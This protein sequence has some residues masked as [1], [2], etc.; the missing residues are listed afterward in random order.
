MKRLR[1][2]LC[3]LMLVLSGCSSSIDEKNERK[4]RNGLAEMTINGVKNP[5]M[6]EDFIYIYSAKD[7]LAEPDDSPKNLCFF[8]IYTLNDAA[9]IK[10]D[11]LLYLQKINSLESQP[12]ATKGQKTASVWMPLSEIQPEFFNPFSTNRSRYNR[13]EECV[14]FLAAN[15]PASTTNFVNN[16]PLQ[17]IEEYRV[18][19]KEALEMKAQFSQVVVNPE[20][21]LSIKLMCRANYVYFYDAKK[22][23][24]LVLDFSVLERS[25]NPN[26]Q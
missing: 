19:D 21:L 1:P 5:Y 11:L 4:W 12:I 20:T 22:K 8:R 23:Y 15:K 6:V 26:C 16:Y 3:L 14:D 9:K 24:F 25:Q 17:V 13:F 18:D 2:L 10:Y 7:R